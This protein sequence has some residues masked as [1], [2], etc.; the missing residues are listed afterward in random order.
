MSGL[1][2]RTEKINDLSVRQIERMY[3]LFQ[4]FYENV[5][6]EKFINDLKAKDRVIILRGRDSGKI[7]GFSTIQD[8]QV[9][10]NGKLVQGIFSGDTVI[11]PAYWGQSALT[12]EFFKNLAKA[13][14]K[15]PMR[16]LYW[17]L[18]S[19][20]FKTYLLLAKN[21]S[22]YY[23]RFDKEL[24]SQNKALVDGFARSLFGEL[25]DSDTMLLKTA[26]KYDRLKKGVAPATAQAMQDPRVAFF[27]RMNPGWADGDELCCVGKVDAGLAIKYLSRTWLKRARRS[28]RVEKT[29]K[30]A[31]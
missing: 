15:R 29:K 21:F 1:K 4:S 12:M 27:C 7:E 10:V 18:I 8:V 14:A 3:E 22:T 23:P 5:K 19:K 11:N 31:S 28:K 20:G 16:P 13:K 2:A 17:F 24:E 25:Y 9:D 6:K 26:F 30:K